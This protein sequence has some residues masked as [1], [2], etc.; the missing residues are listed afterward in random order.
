MNVCMYVY[1]H[2]VYVCTVCSVYLCM[3]V[4]VI[5]MY[6]MYV[7]TNVFYMHVCMYALLSTMNVWQP[8]QV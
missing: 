7:C 3:H 8:C 2:Y 4:C 1:E 5:C 6:C